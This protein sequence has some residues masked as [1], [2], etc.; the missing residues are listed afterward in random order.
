MLHATVSLSTLE[1]RPY[2]IY[3][4]STGLIIA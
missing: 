2:A 4:I 3:P 1:Y